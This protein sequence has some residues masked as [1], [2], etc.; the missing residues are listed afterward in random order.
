MLDSDKVDRA[1]R[2]KMKAECLNRGDLYYRVY[3]DQGIR[4]GST[5]ISKGSKHSLGPGRVSKM[6][7]Q[8]G[9]DTR[10]Q[11]VDLVKCPLSRED[12]LKIMESN[13]SPDKPR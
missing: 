4:V 10:E 12:A 9:L 8:L 1:L 7:R 13:Y 3:N 5:I 6:A 11:F 2:V